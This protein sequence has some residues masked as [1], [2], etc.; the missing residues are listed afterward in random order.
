MKVLLQCN[1]KTWLLLKYLNCVADAVLKENTS[2]LRAMN[3]AQ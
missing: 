2:I 3:F 1:V